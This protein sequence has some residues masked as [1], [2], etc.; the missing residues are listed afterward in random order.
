MVD[1][2]HSPVAN[3]CSI[4][5][6]ELFEKEMVKRKTFDQTEYVKERKEEWKEEGRKKE[7][8][9]ANRGEKKGERKTFLAFE[10]SVAGP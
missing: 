10:K 7:R 8:R 5:D 4:P 6:T 3:F 2:P 1:G 9:G